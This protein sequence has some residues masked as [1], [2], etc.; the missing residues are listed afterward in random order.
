[1]G[2]VL[3]D[4]RL[5]LRSLHRAPTYALA[6]IAALAL[7]I[8][9]NTALF[10]LIE[11]TLLRPY[12]Y[13]HPERLLIVRESS[14][15]FPDSSVAYP[16]FLDWRAQTRESF[17][18][19]A[20]FRRDSFNLTGSGEPE[21]V[22][23]RQ[24]TS[25]F[26]DVLGVQP[27]LGRFFT[28]RDDFA[29]APRTVVLGNALWQRR[30]ASDPRILGQ[31][32]TLGGDSY[33]VIGI[34]PPGFRFL[35]QQDLFVPLGLWADP[36]KDRDDHPGISV[37]ARTRPGVSLEGARAALDAVAQ[38]LEKE[39]PRT[40]TGHR[41][42]AT[43]IQV[44]QTE[45]FRSALF[46]LWG[47][48]GLVLLIA[49]ANVANL[50]L[51]R[52]AA[53]GPELAI[54]SA[55]GAGRRRLMQELLTESVL[56]AVA[57][58]ACGVLLAFWGLDALLPYVPEVLRRNAE[59]HIDG[60]V[61]AFTLALSVVTGLAFGVLP[62]F[63]ASQPD[64]DALLRDA[65]ATDSR[66]RR[67]LRSALVVT[68]IALSLMLLIGAGLLMRSFAR[69]ARVDLGFQPHG[70]VALQLSLPAV[71][72]PDGP[73]EI[74]FEQELRRRLE[75]LPGVRA[76]SVAQSLPLFDDNSMSGFWVE[77]RPRPLPGEGVSAYSYAATPGFLAAMGGRLLRG[78]DLRE[79]DTLRK[80]AVLI[81]DGLARRL[82]PGSDPIG[83]HLSFPPEVVGNMRGP[84]IVGIFA[85][86]QQYG[87]GDA[88]LI[89]SGIMLPFAVGAEFAPQ[90][91]RGMT[92][93]LRSQGE[94][95]PL[96][97]A[98]RREVLALDPELPVYN[99]K[100]MDAAVDDAL[101]GRRFSLVL[102]GLFAAVALLLAAVGVYGVM[103]YGVEQRT[104]EIGIR[105]ALGARQEEVQRMV[106]RDGARLAGAGIAIGIA[107]AVL[108]S[109]VLRGMLF[110]VSTFD[111]LSYV[112]LTLVLAAVA[113]FASWLPARRASKV[114]PGVALRAE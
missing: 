61:L 108:L 50:A 95:G 16:N 75:A 102:L 101:S 112:G 74:R 59:V 4:L 110:G 106:V 33:T 17:S 93:L 68:E 104:R 53:R 111:P 57:G 62:A 10:S 109:R 52:A 12:P 80:P 8:G 20:A 40:N 77:G 49:A 64:L 107:L 28:E 43:P 100:T 22:G 94:L 38:R 65:H 27:Q 32:I 42:R 60:W 71:R 79:D 31:A 63:R 113:L 78:R 56:L 24:V 26:F 19:I 21:R 91:Y 92:V 69:L 82:F 99:V 103:S 9:A 55:L 70:L 88:N 90:W 14:K 7:A 83:Q 76:V 96:V 23:A 73:A 48:V 72:Y 2:S 41:V 3:Q 44:D 11:A 67:K 15:Q 85:H 66:P 37:L 46:V 86:M 81:D 105:M 5:A 36:F 35:T 51:A 45:A 34:L 58:G 39:Y 84:E 6:A 98:A 97:A 54:R 29:G 13:P 1:M 89:D 18:G 47:A 25:D 30:F 87:P 114:D